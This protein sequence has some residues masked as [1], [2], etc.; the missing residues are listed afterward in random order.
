MPIQSLDVDRSKLTIHAPICTASHVIL[1]HPL[2]RFLSHLHNTFN[3]RRLQLLQ[4]RK[5][6]SMSYDGGATPTYPPETTKVRANK[7]WQCA[8]PPKDLLD[9]RVEITGPVDRK[10]SERSERAL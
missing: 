9:R 10:V 2:L 7:H 3:P 4:L 8:A 5:T 1:T 6:L